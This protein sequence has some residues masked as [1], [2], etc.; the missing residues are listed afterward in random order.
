MLNSK[1]HLKVWI[2][3]GLLFLGFPS[4]LWSQKNVI[5]SYF[6]ERLHY[7]P[8][9]KA[10]KTGGLILIQL[11][12]NDKGE[13]IQKDEIR[14]LG[15]GLNQQVNEIIRSVKNWNDFLSGWHGEIDLRIPMVF[16]LRE[17]ENNDLDSNTLHLSIALKSES[18]EQPVYQFVEQEPEYPGGEEALLKFISEKIR[19]PKK[20]LR[21]FI[22][23][24]VYVDFIV[25]SSGSVDQLRVIQGISPECDDEALRVL[26]QMKPW[27]PGKQNGKAVRTQYSIPIAYDLGN[28]LFKFRSSNLM[29]VDTI[30]CWNQ[31]TLYAE[32]PGGRLGLRDSLSNQLQ[33]ALQSNPDLQTV[34]SEFTLQ[35]SKDGK[36]EIKNMQCNDPKWADAIHAALKNLK[37]FKAASF[38]GTTIDSE[39]RIYLELK[40]RSD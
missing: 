23:G 21:E 27:K 18:P 14:T 37:N 32:F 5:Y 13:L 3:S 22:M 17:R 11:K 9:A 6:K 10:A 39:T 36:P 24:R 38:K 12:V 33:T 19:Y 29:L 8:K 26:A 2:L 35:I 1:N 25:D 34:S 7:T 28:G 4:K 30:Y 15:N 40:R 16:R 20:A 31:D